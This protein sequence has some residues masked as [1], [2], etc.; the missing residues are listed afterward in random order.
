MHTGPWE[1]FEVSKPHFQTDPITFKMITMNLSK[2]PEF[3]NMFWKFNQIE[4]ADWIQ[5]FNKTKVQT[6]K[7]TTRTHKPLKNLNM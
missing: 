6:L 2:R 4:G 1:K 3:V 7:K 5:Y